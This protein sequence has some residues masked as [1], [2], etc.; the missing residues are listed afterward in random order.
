MSGH[1]HPSDKRAAFTGLILGAVALFV[2]L[3]AITK[4]TNDHYANEK[5]PAAGAAK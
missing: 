1:H 2:I 3:F 4:M 5:A